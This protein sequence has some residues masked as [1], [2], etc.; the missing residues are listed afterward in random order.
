LTTLGHCL[1]KSEAS[2]HRDRAEQPNANQKGTGRLIFKQCS[3]LNSM[4]HVKCLT[5]VRFKSTKAGFQW[6]TMQ[7]RFD[8]LPELAAADHAFNLQDRCGFVLISDQGPSVSVTDFP[9]F[10]SISLR[11]L[12]RLTSVRFAGKAEMIFTLYQWSKSL[13]IAVCPTEVKL[14]RT[15]RPTHVSV[16]LSL[17]LEA[18]FQSSKRGVFNLQ[19]SIVCGENLLHNRQSQPCS[20]RF[21]VELFSTS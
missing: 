9:R 21:A 15:T 2:P 1:G 19:R 12:N 17:D 6:P 14:R 16:R 18:C 3:S 13:Q 4:T 7:S 10:K 5:S 8:R 20:V 11:E